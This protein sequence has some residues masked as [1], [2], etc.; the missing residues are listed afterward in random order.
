MSR[1]CTMVS[2]PRARRAA[3]ASPALRHENGGNLA[4]GP[5]QRAVGVGYYFLDGNHVAASI[6]ATQHDA[7][8]AAAHQLHGAELV[9]QDERMLRGRWSL[10]A[11]GWDGAS[12]RWG[13]TWTPDS[14]TTWQRI[15]CGA[16]VSDGQ[17]SC[18]SFRMVYGVITIKCYCLLWLQQHV[19]QLMIHAFCSF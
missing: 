3:A 17:R 16:S 18:Q 7:C 8:S 11:S 9:G 19:Q 14:S 1:T 5:L 10:G 13:G 2:Q 12:N 15:G 4:Q 6:G